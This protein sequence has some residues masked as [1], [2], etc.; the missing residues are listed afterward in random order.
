MEEARVVVIG[1]GQA[2]FGATRSWPICSVTR[3]ATICPFAR[4]YGSTAWSKG[5]AGA[6]C[7]GHPTV[8]SSA[9]PWWCARGPTSDRTGRT[10]S[11][12]SRPGSSSSMPRRTPSR[13]RFPTADV[14]DRQ[15]PDRLPDRRGPPAVGPGGVPRLRAGAV[16]AATPR[17]P[18]H[19]HLA[20]GDRLLRRAAQRAPLPRRPPLFANVQATGRDG[21]HDLHYRV[22]QTM[23][24]EL[25]GR[26]TAVEG[27]RASFAD[28]LHES[29]AFGDGR[30][31]DTRNILTEQIAGKGRPAPTLPEPVPFGPT[32]RANFR[33]TDSVRSSSRQ[34]SGRTTRAGCASRLRRPGLSDHR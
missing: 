17:R 22:L 21:G 28:D 25:L 24:V 7:C 6:S 3:R 26:L 33:S 15:R 23:G 34:G 1:G 4:E 29:V 8:M 12:P 9:R 14:G 13:M 20:E 10:S 5:R 27:S 30:Y 11:V 18:R 2:S 19:R 32:H 31:A 16:A